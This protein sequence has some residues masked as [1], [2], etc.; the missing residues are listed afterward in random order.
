MSYYAEKKARLGC[1]RGS[2]G[3][4]ANEGLG[5]NISA[6]VNTEYRNNTSTR[7]NREALEVSEPRHYDTIQSGHEVESRNLGNH[8]CND[9]TPGQ[10]M[11]R[12]ASSPTLQLNRAYGIEPHPDPHSTRS[13]RR[14]P[15]YQNTCWRAVDNV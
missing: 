7:I 6:V 8:A 10:R 14:E 4:Y 13:R 12:S 1:R 11:T 9:V 15:I 3:E 5:P 2:T